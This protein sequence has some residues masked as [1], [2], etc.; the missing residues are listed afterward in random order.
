MFEGHILY[1]NFLFRH[2]WVGWNR[3]ITVLKSFKFWH[4][5]Y[6]C[7]RHIRWFE[8][9]L[10]ILFFCPDLTTVMPFILR[11]TFAGFIQRCC[12]NSER[13]WRRCDHVTPALADCLPALF[14]ID[15]WLKLLSFKAFKYLALLYKRIC[16]WVS[17]PRCPWVNK[18]APTLQKFL[19]FNIRGFIFGELDP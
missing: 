19:P 1:S 14:H 8:Y 12:L 11:Q 17:V 13:C 4:Y 6:I 10:Y 2:R 9:M 5:W 3:S 18:G 16:A 7:R 15:F